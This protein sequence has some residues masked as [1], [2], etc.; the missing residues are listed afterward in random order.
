[1]RIKHFRKLI[2]VAAAIVIAL[3]CFSGCTK[4]QKDSAEDFAQ[5]P[6][7]VP[8]VSHTP[9]AEPSPSPEPEPGFDYEYKAP[10]EG[11]YDGSSDIIALS[12]EEYKNKP[13]RI[14]EGTVIE[15]CL[16]EVYAQSWGNLATGSFDSSIYDALLYMHMNDP[17]DIRGLLAESWS[18]SDDRLEWTFKIREGVKFADGTVCDAN[19]ITKAWDMIA[20]RRADSM[21]YTIVSWQAV[22]DYE[23]VVTLSSYIA[24]FEQYICSLYIPSPTAIELNGWDSYKA[25]V[26]TGPYCVDFSTFN[27]N[28]RRHITLKANG[29]YF[30]PER[31]P[32]IETVNIKLQEG[33]GEQ[34]NALLES[35]LHAG[36]LS[37]YDGYM[38]DI[39][40]LD[41][42][43]GTVKKVYVHGGA[44]WLD[45]ADE[46]ILKIKEV[47]TALS[48]FADF[49]EINELLYK[50]EGL[51]KDSIWAAGTSVYLETDAYYYAPDEGHELLA[52]VGLSASD[53]VLEQYEVNSIE[54]FRLLSEQLSRKGVTL[55]L[56]E[57]EN[58][59]NIRD[60]YKKQ[61]LFTSINYSTSIMPYRM[62]EIDANAQANEFL[63]VK[64]CR[65][66]LYDAELYE[67]MQSEYE[68]VWSSDTWSELLEHCENLTRYAQEDMC[69]IGGVQEPRWLALDAK[70]KNGVYFSTV[71]DYEL[72]LYYLYI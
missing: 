4:P 69:V 5:T 41:E 47:R 35:K 12:W 62:W 29:D 7:P 14:Q 38:S 39:G 54:L 25:C 48:R 28:W 55:E 34:I 46:E 26:G 71:F 32:S 40:R 6:S 65:Q 49:E 3:S 33:T 15:V 2:A 50:G 11:K 61:P 10:E 42:Y 51:V 57:Y 53:I 22:S 60:F 31:Y 56:E 37:Y 64:H 45:P 72:Q 23:F 63:D 58:T 66:E 44:V 21:G 36:I 27:E 59:L 24:W 1:M 68:Q 13:C 16:P 30:L 52:S 18:C 20:Q 70:L 67:L 9:T 17:E 19:A 43:E 8:E